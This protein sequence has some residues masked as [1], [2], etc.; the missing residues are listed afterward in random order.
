MT[1]IF[2]NFVD[3]SYEKYEISNIAADV[4]LPLCVIV[5]TSKKNCAKVNHLDMN[6]RHMLGAL[7]MHFSQ[8]WPNFLFQQPIRSQQTSQHPTYTHK[9]V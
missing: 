3:F 4:D 7:H 6:S 9:K 8:S 5:A 1:I 2:A